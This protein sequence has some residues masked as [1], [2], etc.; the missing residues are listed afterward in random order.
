MKK[1]RDDYLTIFF[2]AI[3]ATYI[4]AT[5]ALP[6]YAILSKSIENKEGLFIGLSNYKYYFSNPSL[7]YSIYNSLFVSIITTIISVTLSFMFA[8]ALTRSCMRAKPFFKTMAMIPILLPSL[9]AG[10]ALIYLFGN[11]GVFKALLMGRSIYG[12][13]GIIIAEVFYTFPHALLIIITALSI[14][15]A[16]L[17]EAATVLRSSPIRTFFTVTIP[18]AKYGLMSACFVVFTLVITDFGIPKVIGGQYNV[19]AI[20]VYKQVIGQQNFEMGA[21][22]SVVLIIPALLAFIVDR[23]VQKKQISILTARS[24]VYEPK[25]NKTFDLM[26]FLYCSLITLFILTM[27][28]MC[29]YASLIKFWP[30]NLSFSLKNYHFDLMDGGGWDSYYN[31]IKMAS[32]TAFFGTIIVFTS[33]YF[34]E[35]ARTI[36]TA[37][38]MMHLLSMMPMAIPGMVLGLAYIFFFNNPNNPFNFIYGTMAI[39]VI[40]TITHFYTVSHLTAITA[41]KQIDYEF[42]SVSSSLKQPFYKMFFSVTVPISLPVIFEIG[43]YFFVNAMTTVSAVVF[44]YGPK[45]TLAS[46]AVLNMDDA[47]DIAPAAAMGMMIFYTNAFVRISYVIITKKVLVKF[48][49]WRTK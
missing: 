7:F 14:A 20:D 37:R 8:Y 25:K 12:P 16:R 6:M 21:V 22:V 28:G 23:I 10:I 27:V 29:L 38:I 49:Q 17:Y 3:A 19:L 33:A 13:I 2:I 36:K 43:I 18:S 39:L 24:V 31:S 46:V 34:I 9:L 5:L 32:Y 30:Y 45:T 41:L 44:I 26:M 48:Q 35:K 1:S 11:Q 47:G 40:C 4:L 15:D 42:E